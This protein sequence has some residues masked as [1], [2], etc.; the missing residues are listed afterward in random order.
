MLKNNNRGRS[1]FFLGGV[2]PIKND[3]TEG[4]HKHVLK[5][6][7]EWPEP[8]SSKRF[9]SHVKQLKPEDPGVADLV[10]EGKYSAME[11]PKR[12]FEQKI[13]FCFQQLNWLRSSE[14]RERA[15]VWQKS[16]YNHRY[17]CHQI[18]NLTEDQ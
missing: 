17:W 9:W 15:K 13:L 10:I 14:R 12:N 7:N 6:D 8:F 2:A 4:W 3:V 11:R 18:A 5:V 16:S 1:R